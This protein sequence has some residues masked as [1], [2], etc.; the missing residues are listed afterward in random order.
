MVVLGEIPELDLTQI[1]NLPNGADDAAKSDLISLYKSTNQMVQKFTEADAVCRV[2]VVL[3]SIFRNL[4]EKFVVN[5]Q[6][7][8]K[9]YLPFTDF[10]INVTAANGKC[11]IIEVKNLQ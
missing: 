10:L 7:S 4:E 6:P 9:G 5:C 2:F 8:V 11:I 3:L 1:S